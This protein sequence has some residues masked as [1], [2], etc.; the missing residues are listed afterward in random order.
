MALK[1]LLIITYNFPPSA[2]VGGLRLLGFSRHLPKYGW[3]ADVV[4]PP[5]MP[6]EPD[7]QALLDQVP[8][9]TVIYSVPFTESR[10]IRRLAATDSWLPKA[11]IACQRAIRKRRPDAILTSG[12]PHHV[13]LLGLGLKRWHGIPW[14]SDFRDPWAWTIRLR[15]PVLG[16]QTSSA[17]WWENILE[18]AVVSQS[19]AVILNAPHSRETFV[20]EYPEH[21]GKTL[22]ITNGYD[23]ESFKNLAKPDVDD[24]IRLLY[25]GQIYAGRDPRPF[26]DAV[27]ALLANR[28]E[29]Q[30]PI[31]VD[32][33]GSYRTT[34]RE[35]DL[36]IEIKSRG[37]EHTKSVHGEIS[38]T[39]SLAEMERSDI[40]LLFDTPGRR[41]GVPAKLYEYIGSGRS[42]WAMAETDGDT[43]WVLRQS[44]S[45]YRFAN[46]NESGSI[47]RCMNE[48]IEAI[49]NGHSVIDFNPRM[50]AFTRD[51]LTRQ[52]ASVLDECTD[53][54][55]I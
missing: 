8:A 26:F 47:L 46:P 45:N 48:L 19:D 33:F 21:T 49:E 36:D 15:D 50:Q 3:Q 51:N 52:L 35:S 11:W 2:A 27:R 42:I 37:L 13:H 25:C 44:D 22:V 32:F 34:G 39:Q 41:I 53:N 43:A 18:R 5:K 38:N 28:T 16:S 14:V 40:L 1:N 55:S 9:E 31:R 20:A 7:D 24:S 17:T 10:I 29:G 4:A 12:P 6:W 30:R 23:P 54:R